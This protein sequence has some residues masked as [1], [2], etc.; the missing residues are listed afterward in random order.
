MRLPARLNRLQRHGRYL[1]DDLSEMR[2]REWI[3]RIAELAEQLGID[4]FS[5]LVKKDLEGAQLATPISAFAQSGLQVS[6]RFSPTLP[7][8]F[9]PVCIERIAS[10]RPER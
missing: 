6:A 5:T 7:G 1:R 3:E 4:D 9:R 10:E 8:S 2:N